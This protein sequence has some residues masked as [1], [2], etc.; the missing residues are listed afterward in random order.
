MAII[1]ARG[2]SKRIPRKNIKDF[3]GKPVIA[4]SIET[5]LKA[6]IFHEVMVSTEDREIAEI[7]ISYGAKVPFLRSEKNADD[8]AGTEDVVLEVLNKYEE[9]N[10][11]FDIVCCIYPTTPL[12]TIEKLIESKNKMLQENYDTL[13]PVLRYGHPIQRALKINDNKLEMVWPEYEQARTQDL[14]VYFHD[15]GQYYWLD[16]KQ[17][18]LRKQIFSSNTGFIELSQMEAQDIDNIDDWKLAELK[19]KSKEKIE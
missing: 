18:K 8:I 4:R 7:S 5:A 6:G 16:V 9:R 14:E 11:Q 2:G 15:A 12:M 1:P 17:F 10:I 19:F 13:F 3:L